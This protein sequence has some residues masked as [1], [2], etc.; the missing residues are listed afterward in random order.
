MNCSVLL[1]RILRA[2]NNAN[3]NNNNGN[4]NNSRKIKRSMVGCMPFMEV[5][6]M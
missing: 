3:I 6:K 4:N 5:F 2:N 1:H